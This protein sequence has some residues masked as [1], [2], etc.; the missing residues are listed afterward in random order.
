MKCSY[1]KSADFR[2][3]DHAETGA[4]ARGHKAGE[5]EDVR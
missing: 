5:R 4:H 3:K 2:F 1:L